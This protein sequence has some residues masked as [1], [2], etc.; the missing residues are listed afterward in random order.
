LSASF[1]AQVRRS[2]NNDILL[3]KLTI[4]KINNEINKKMAKGKTMMMNINLSKLAKTESVLPIDV[5]TKSGN[6]VF[7]LMKGCNNKVYT[8]G[9]AAMAW[10]AGKNPLQL[11][12]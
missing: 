4:P 7:N 3:G 5:K 10:M 6:M 2:G 9:H 11:L 12:H 8:E 1:L